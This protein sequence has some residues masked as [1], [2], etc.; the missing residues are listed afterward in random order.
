MAMQVSGW[1]LIARS[2][3]L[4]PDPSLRSHLGQA[5]P[6]RLGWGDP[7]TNLPLGKDHRA[8]LS[9]LCAWL[10]L[11]I[12]STAPSLLP[13]LPC[14]ALQGIGSCMGL[15]SPGWFGDTPAVAQVTA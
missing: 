5:G 12:Q 8:L 4:T 3:A 9:P 2:D 6:S 15:P 13:W 7:T 11:R 1:A 14:A 10:S